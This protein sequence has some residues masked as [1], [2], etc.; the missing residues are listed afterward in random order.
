MARDT[1]SMIDPDDLMAALE[2][3]DNDGFCLD[4]GAQQGGCEPD[5]RKYECECCGEFKVY[6]AQELALMGALG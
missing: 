5:A 2:D 4:C 3:D 1:F 6:G